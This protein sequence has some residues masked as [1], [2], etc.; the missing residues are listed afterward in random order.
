MSVTFGGVKEGYVIKF[1]T[2][3]V[4]VGEATFIWERLS[5]VDIE[6]LI[7]ETGHNLL[8][9]GDGLVANIQ[10]GRGHNIVIDCAKEYEDD[11]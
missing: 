10:R 11:Q 1:N 4:S 2:R 9:W 6:S 7:A 5:P 8:V 3:N